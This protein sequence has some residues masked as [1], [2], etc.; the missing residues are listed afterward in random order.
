MKKI[1]VLTCMT[2]FSVS[3]LR[4]QNAN[5]ENG[6]S[7]MITVFLKHIQNSPV[8]SIQANAMRQHFYQ[9]IEAS[10]A[11]IVS[12]YVAM[13]LGQILTLKFP[14]KD[15]RTVNNI[16]ER[17]AWGSFHTEMFPTYDF[18]PVYPVMLAK[19]KALDK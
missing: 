11:R 17:G 3:M 2:V 6:D 18:K 16:F 13:G 4:A 5:S 8:D 14:A 1:I 19:E 10:H 7:T 9:K 15:L 12:W